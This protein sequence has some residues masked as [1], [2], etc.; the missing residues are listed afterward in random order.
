MREGKEA[1]VVLTASDHLLDASEDMSAEER[2]TSFNAMIT[3]A[4]QALLS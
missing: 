1:L 4:A 3:I 2:E